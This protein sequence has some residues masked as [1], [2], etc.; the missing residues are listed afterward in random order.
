MSNQKRVA[1]VILNWNG[2]NMMRQFLPSVVKGTGEDG[3]VIVADNGS[4]D[5]SCDMLS[6]EFP[7][8][9][10][11]RL[12]KNYGF[13]EGYNQALKQ[14]DAEFF[15]LLNSDVEVSEGWLKPLLEYM[16]SHQDV[17]ACQPKILSF[18]ERNRFEYAGAAGGFLDIYGY[19]YCRGRVFAD[20]END[21]GQY[22]DIANVLWATGA[23]NGRT[24][25][26]ILC[27]SGRN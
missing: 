5:D 17:A 27:P 13:A 6:R 26:R 24:R 22:D 1:V 11:I 25:R 2:S 18:K 7:D 20:V 23:C 9:K 10:Q 16:D 21:E 14:T 4:S 8:I 19:P 3:E 12:P 15:L